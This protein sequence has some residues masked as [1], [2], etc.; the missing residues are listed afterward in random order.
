MSDPLSVR[1]ALFSFAPGE[2][3]R[4]ALFL[5]YSFDGR[6]FEQAVVPDLLERR[7]DK[8]LVVR[9][10]NAV[11]S[12]APSARYRKVNAYR[13]A[14]FH[15]KLI[16]LIGESK[17]RAVIGSANLTRSAFE[18]R[19][20]FGR[21]YDLSP[22]EVQNVGLFVALLKYLT[23]GVST[24]LRGDAGRDLC[25]IAEALQQTIKLYG[26][27][28]GSGRHALLHNYDR[29]IWSQLETMLPHKI[30]RR[31]LIVSPFFER[32]RD[33]P[34]DPAV[35]T[36]DASIFDQLLSINFEFN[37]SKSEAPVRVY[38][39]QSEG[40][41]E[42]PVQKLSQYGDR[43]SFFCQKEGEEPLHAKFLLL[44]GAEGAGRR[45]YLF[46][47]HGSPNFTTAALGKVPPNGNSELAVLTT[48]PA[49]R[50]T[51]GQVIDILGLSK[52]FYPMQKL[53]LLTPIEPGEPPPRR[54]QGVADTTYQV[55][56][57]LL[58]IALPEPIPNGGRIRIYLERDGTP[59]L[60]GEAEV[61]GQLD[62]V[63]PVT[64][65]AEIDRQTGLLKLCGTTVRIDILDADGAVLSSDMAPVNVDTPEEF[66]GLS[67]TASA[68]LTLDERIARAGV[69]RPL[70]YR[71][72]QKWLEKRR[73][74]KG[75]TDATIAAHQADLDRFY[76][77]VHSG[78]RGILARCKTSANSEPSL[79]RNLDVLTRWM[80][81][82]AA[83]ENP[84]YSRECYLF[85]V[86]RLL[87][88][89]VSVVDALTPAVQA[90]VVPKIG[91]D[92]RLVDRFDKVCS[93]LSDV[94]DP[95]GAA[96][97]QQTIAQAAKISRLL[98]GGE[99]R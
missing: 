50:G 46:A 99:G 85:V 63:V 53:E 49:T 37:P 21:V 70:T 69:G 9:D 11:V 98:N 65:L 45:P 55:A 72:R 12:E 44:E 13:S 77:N 58:K 64:G 78:L 16:L 79:R 23:E 92:L 43:V 74:Q 40:K 59:A 22:T 68:P 4:G 39:R 93:W 18:H 76:R 54:P 51:W 8:M 73:E 35:A 25:E 83:E 88:T 57:K 71:E 42:L 30:L 20:E 38:F 17:A 94:D 28:Q 80:V 95:V 87:R 1:D 7:I 3:L 86:D 2:E 91:I 60:I 47:L 96:Y 31:A 26:A 66:C 41:T 36:H 61:F 14:V 33:H 6:W 89:A 34:E 84:E 27:P 90:T 29:S 56:D 75:G 32:D 62:V 81:E 97:A 67:R 5:T 52:S 48:L 15:P 82:A 19:R 10:R 24:E